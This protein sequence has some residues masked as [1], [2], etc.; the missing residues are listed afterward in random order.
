MAALIT[1]GIF[2]PPV[3]M[4]SAG[5]LGFGLTAVQ[6]GALS[7]AV[8]S[9]GLSILAGE[10]PKD[11][12]KSAALGAAMG[13]LGGKLQQG[14]FEAKAFARDAKL[15]AGGQTTTATVPVAGSPGTFTPA[16]AADYAVG[17]A[18]YNTL[19]ESYGATIVD[20]TPVFSSGFTPTLNEAGT[21]V[22]GA[23]RLV[24]G[25]TLAQ[26]AADAGIAG[27]SK[28]GDYATQ[29]AISAGVNTGMN[30]LTAQITQE[31]PPVKFG[32]SSGQYYQGVRNAVANLTRNYISSGSPS[33]NT[34]AA[35]YASMANNLSYGTGSIDYNQHAS[36][37]LMRGINVPSLQYT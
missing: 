32:G 20:G 1:A 36:L 18:N 16:T 23:E 22:T 13:A 33:G 10:K 37:G 35:I 4:A 27:S 9:G 24:E 5:P 21:T 8:A 15:V 34:T 19:A 29:A 17:S 3:F 2:L 28:V 12:L 7:G 31:D 26:S 14:K 11:F 30:L 6:A 25:S